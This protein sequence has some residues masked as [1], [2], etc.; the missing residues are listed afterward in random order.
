MSGDDRLFGGAG[1]DSLHGDSF[2]DGCDGGPGSD[3]AAMGAA[4]PGVP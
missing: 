3:P 2:T 1:H 4:V